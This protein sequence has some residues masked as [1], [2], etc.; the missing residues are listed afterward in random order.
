VKLVAGGCWPPTLK[1]ITC[2]REGVLPPWS[3]IIIL[4]APRIPWYC[5]NNTLSLYFMNVN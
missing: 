2:V 1:T 5:N 3:V 4:Y